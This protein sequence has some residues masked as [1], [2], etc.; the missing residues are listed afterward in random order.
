MRHNIQPE[1]NPVSI[2]TLRPTQITVGMAEVERKR[3]DWRKRG[4]HEDAAFL[5][6][7]MIPCIKG[8]KDVLWVIDHHHL[9]LAVHLEDVKQV[10]VSI[11]ADLSMLDKHRFVNFMDNRSWLHL[12]NADGEKCDFDDLPKKVT[13]LAD[14]PYR[15]LAGEVRE[16]GG[17]AKDLTPF[18]E[19]LWADF[20]RRKIDLKPGKP[21]PEE[22]ITKALMMA[23]SSKAAY[24]PGWCGAD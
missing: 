5:G 24:L 17:Y 4:L 9:A 1:L 2:M 3:A 6:S 12:Y 10:L 20:F 13:K 15:S 21:L 16:S 19:F 11:V 18:A 8:P 7:H 23:H 14:D 22:A